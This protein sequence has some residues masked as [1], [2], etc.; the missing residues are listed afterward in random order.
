MKTLTRRRPAGEAPEVGR[1]ADRRNLSGAY[2][3]GLWSEAQAALLGRIAGAMPQV[4]ELAAELAEVLLGGAAP[5][6]QMFRALPDDERIAA[7]RSLAAAAGS[8]S[9][10]AAEIDAAIAGYA[11]AR[12]RWG[13][14]RDGLWYTH[15]GGRTF[16]AA[17][18][19]DAAS[20]LVAREVK[21]ADLE[22]DLARVTALTGRLLR[23]T[24]PNVAMRRPAAGAAPKEPRAPEAGRAKRAA[25]KRVPGKRRRAANRA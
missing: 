10:R 7:L 20:F 16:L 24:R 9:K 6:G 2:A 21:V 12:R 8:G 13:T 19:R 23:L 17:P 15:E 3:A 22:A 4:E 1:A 18:A 11:A 25:P 14:L 5:A